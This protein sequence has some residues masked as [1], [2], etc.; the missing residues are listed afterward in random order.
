[1]ELSLEV[2][3]WFMISL[4]LGLAVLS[5]IIG[6]DYNAFYENMKSVFENKDKVDTLSGM[7]FQETVLASLE[8]WKN[9]GFGQINKTQAIYYNE[10]SNPLN[11]ITFMEKINTLNLNRIINDTQINI[12]GNI[13][14]KKI[15][16]VECD[17][18]NK[19]LKIS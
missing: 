6:V 16:L 4:V 9:C 8:V 14:D 3:V 5:F 13:E 19:Q 1:M 18:V 7:N 17:P 10:T 12:E 15:L 11:N 2:V